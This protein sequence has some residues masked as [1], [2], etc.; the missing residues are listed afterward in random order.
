MNTFRNSAATLISGL[1]V[2]AAGP[3]S[4]R[5]HVHPSGAAAYAQAIGDDAGGYQQVEHGGQLGLVVGRVGPAAGSPALVVDVPRPAGGPGVAE[6]RTVGSRD[7]RHPPHPASTAGLNGSLGNAVQVV[8]LPR[9]RG[10]VGAVGGREVHAVGT[11]LSTSDPGRLRAGAALSG[12]L[13][14]RSI[15]SHPQR[16]AASAR[17]R[18]SRARPRRTRARG[19][20]RRCRARRPAARRRRACCRARCRDPPAA[21][22]AGS[23]PRRAMRSTASR[24][25]GP[26]SHRWLPRTSPVRHSLC[27]RTSGTR[28]PDRRAAVARAR[29]RGARARR[30]DPSKVKTRASASKPSSS[31]SGSPTWPRTVAGAIVTAVAPHG[32]ARRTAADSA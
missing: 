29:A 32:H 6:R 7:D 20:P 17:P 1:A 10:E 4:A 14:S 19:W 27:S 16:R 15:R 21:G 9:L 13:V 31:R 23:R 30:R 8:S 22:R 26:Q 24:S 18:C 25:C 28:R 3:A 5:E 12:L 11:R 2:F